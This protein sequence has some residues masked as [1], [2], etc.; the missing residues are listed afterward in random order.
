MTLGQGALILGVV[1]L[2]LGGAALFFALTHAGPTGP[3]GATGAA[4]SAGANGATGT[5][6]AT[7]APGAQ[8]APGPQGPTGLSATSLW[9]VVNATGAL[10][11]G[12]G[13]VSTAP[14]GTGDFQ[15]IFDQDV[16]NC[17]YIA[18]LGVPGSQGGGTQVPGF[19]TTA[20]RSLLTDG[21]WVQTFN[22]TGVLT[23]EPFNL[24][25]FC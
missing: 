24:A 16:R 25:V 6:G 21:V 11:N 1:A 22:E 10:Q 19:I 9:A 2:A 14:E 20:G 5:Q 7:G 15:V 17:S 8:G 3:T 23:A 4:G 18:T 13:V 12:S